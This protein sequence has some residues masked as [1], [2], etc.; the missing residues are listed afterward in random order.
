MNAKTHGGYVGL[1]VILVTTAIMALLFSKMYLTPKPEAQSGEMRE[2]QPLTA[3]G[4][5]ATTTMAQMH[6]D[7]DAANAIRDALNK[8]NDEERKMMQE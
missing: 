1:I 4:T 3:S 7:I 8:H 2:V 6:A 5:V